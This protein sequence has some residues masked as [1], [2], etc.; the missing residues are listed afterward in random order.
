MEGIRITGY[1][2]RGR[3]F[4]WT[5][6]PCLLEMFSERT[7]SDVIIKFDSVKKETTEYRKPLRPMHSRK[8]LACLVSISDGAIKLV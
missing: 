8:K 2:T 3:V 1:Q 5:P 6:G 4:D 7:T